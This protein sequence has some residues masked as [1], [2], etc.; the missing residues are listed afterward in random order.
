MKSLGFLL[1]LTC[2]MLLQSC[3]QNSLP[4]PPDLPS[5]GDL[6]FVHKID[7][8]QGNVIT[9]DMIA[10]LT[11]GMDKK[12]VTFI[13]GSPVI[14]DTFHTDRWD[15]LYVFQHGGGKAKRRRITLYFSDSKLARIEGDI[16]AAAG[17]LVVD[18]RQDM[19]VDVPDTARQ[20]LLAKIKDTM[21]FVGQEAP[22]VKSKTDA[23]KAVVLADDE[24]PDI[25]APAKTAPALT[26]IQRA[27]LEEQGGPGVL[28]K[29]KDAMPFR[30]DSEKKP[31]ADAVANAASQAAPKKIKDTVNADEQSAEAPDSPGLL[32]KLKGALPFSKDTAASPATQRPPATREE[33]HTES[34]TR[35]KS[36]SPAVA[37]DDAED[38]ADSEQTA[39]IIPPPGAPTAMPLENQLSRE[40]TTDTPRKAA[41]AD[42]DDVEGIDVPPQPARKKRG[43]FARLFGK[44]RPAD[45][46][47]EP[48]NRE[49][50]RYRDISDPEAN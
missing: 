23:K 19:T 45:E 48:D 25:Q 40:S 50:R 13:M 9:Q 5:I 43:F 21:P 30:G 28:A 3:A 4:R 16:K 7:I 37:E 46:N 49:R 12:K 18:T 33:A 35:D 41:K 34:I 15:Y 6:P 10:Q 42:P 47:P 38:T 32:A 36:N 1:I 24:V 2:G 29:I 20:G 27:A 26:P 22:P 39:V 44:D 14:L 11:L 31:P 8:Q 17:K